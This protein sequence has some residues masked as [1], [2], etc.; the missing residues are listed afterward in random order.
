MYS[1]Q[2]IAQRIKNTAKEKN[3]TISQLLSNCK[4][5]QNTVAKMSNGADILTLSIVKIADGLGCSVDYLLGRT[6]NGT[7]I[8]I[9]NSSM[10]NKLFEYLNKLNDESKKQALDYL[11]YLID[12]QGKETD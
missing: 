8:V 11:E 5:G 12:K 3:I 9:D 4:L 7:E 6:N 10:E 2:D 1:T